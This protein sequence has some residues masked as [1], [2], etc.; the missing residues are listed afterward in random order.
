MV[1]VVAEDGSF[2]TRPVRLGPRLYGYR[3]IREGL[4]GDETIVVNGLTRLRPGVIVDPKLVTLPPEAT[5]TETS[6]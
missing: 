4:T 3:V 5:A 2:L 1:Y 6:Q